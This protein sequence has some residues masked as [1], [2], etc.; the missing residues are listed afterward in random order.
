MAIA[1]FPML[2]SWTLNS[3]KET[4]WLLREHALPSA[5]FQHPRMSSRVESSLI[6]VLDPGQKHAG[7]TGWGNFRSEIAGMTIRGF[8]SASWFAEITTRALVNRY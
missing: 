6:E 8:L 4:E 7:V 2:T 5:S 3:R 1:L